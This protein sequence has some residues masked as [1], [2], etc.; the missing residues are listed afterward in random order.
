MDQMK[1][2]DG[3]RLA[4]AIHSVRAVDPESMRIVATYAR[5]RGMPLHVH[6]AEQPAEVEECMEVEG[7]T[8]AQLLDREG[9]LGP[10]LVAIHPIHLEEGDVALVGQNQAVV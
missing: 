8:P 2:T 3:A 4:A 10:D 7:C 6:L 1:D 9:I 5:E